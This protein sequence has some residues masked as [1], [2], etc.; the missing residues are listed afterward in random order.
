[1]PSRSLLPLASDQANFLLPRTPAYCD[2]ESPSGYLLRLAEA[3]GYPN[4]GWILEEIHWHPDHRIRRGWDFTQLQLVLGNLRLLPERFGYSRG[5]RTSLASAQ[6]LGWP[7]HNGDLNIRS[8]R[9][10]PECVREFGYMRAIW[11]LRVVS[12]CVRHQRRLVDTC[13]S[14]GN[15]LS[16]RRPGLLACRC[17]FDLSY[18]ARQPASDGSLALAELME[19]ALHRHR[20]SDL[21]ERMG[22][23]V[24]QLATAEAGVLCR[25]FWVLD[26]ANRFV[27]GDSTAM[28][29]KARGL[30]ATEDHGAVLADWPHAFRRLLHSWKQLNDRSAKPIQRF[31]TCF[32]WVFCRLGKNL[33]AREYQLLFVVQEAL[34]W[35]AREWDAQPVKFSRRLFPNAKVPQVRFGD[36]TEAARVM[37][38]PMYTVCR[39]AVSGRIPIH[40]MASSKRRRAWIFDLDVIRTLNLTRHKAPGIRGAAKRIGWPISIVRMLRKDGS[41]PSDYL[42]P[43]EGSFAEED[44]RSFVDAVRARA[45][46]GRP[47]KDVVNASTILAGAYPAKARLELARK[48][49]SGEVHSWVA[50]SAWN[51]AHIAIREG[52]VAH[53]RGLHDRYGVLSRRQVGKW[54]GLEPNPAAALYR[55]LE[56][57]YPKARRET[58]LKR[59]REFLRRYQPLR[60]FAQARGLDSRIARRLAVDTGRKVIALES[61]HQSARYGPIKSYFVEILAATRR[62]RPSRPK[63]AKQDRLRAKGDIRKVRKPTSSTPTSTKRTGKE[64]IP[65]RR[66]ARL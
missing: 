48:I 35:G 33:Q 45:S 1:M 51:L 37:G 47:P 34:T 19:R 16:I 12:V 46:R 22:F 39:W 23:P 21:P 32:N 3:N 26:H 2:G 13:P 42:T 54:F 59:A 30:R 62:I 66:V 57:T 50:A 6:L 53:I 61:G 25:L 9:V 65:P 64:S 7:L 41:I 8:G 5:E 44:M 20:I 4:I 55:F 36:A 29:S 43:Y 56:S 28:S 11:E 17:G 52:D 60:E 63:K 58:Q 49:M 24:S 14:C 40:R 15:V 31:Q 38:I 18:C 27:Q 10:C